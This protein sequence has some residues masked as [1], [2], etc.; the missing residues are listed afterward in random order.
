[1]QICHPQ[2]LH[3]IIAWKN[4]LISYFLNLQ[5]Q[6]LHQMIIIL[7]WLKIYKKG[8]VKSKNE[9][10]NLNSELYIA[11]FEVLACILAFPNF[12]WSGRFKDEFN[13]GNIPLER[14]EFVPKVFTLA[15][16]IVLQIITK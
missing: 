7:K 15:I 8:N 1:M 14:E 10:D 11:E 16:Y 3:I 9:L 13:M 5:T 12:A 4:N 6:F 2:I